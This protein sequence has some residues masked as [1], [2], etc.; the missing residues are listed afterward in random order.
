MKKTVKKRTPKQKYWL[1]GYLKKD[2]EFTWRLHEESIWYFICNTL[3]ECKTDAEVGARED[4]VWYGPVE[5]TEDI[6]SSAMESRE[7]GVLLDKEIDKTGGFKFLED[8]YK[9]KG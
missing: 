2:G 4:D 5:V 3:K 1:A 8:V 7:M 6:L 9:E